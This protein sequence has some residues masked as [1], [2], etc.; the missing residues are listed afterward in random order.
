MGYLSILHDY[1]IFD[2]ILCVVLLITAYC[3]EY[4]TNLPSKVPNL[5][6]FIN[7]NEKSEI[8]SY[9]SI[10]I[11]TYGVGTFF[12]F[13]LGIITKID[14]TIFKK[15]SA[16]LFSISLTCFIV[17]IAKRLVERPRPDTL[18]VCGANNV[19][20]CNQMINGYKLYYQFTS[21][22]SRNAAEIASSSTFISMCLY[23][24]WTSDMMYSAFFK[25][26]PICWA[27]FIGGVEIVT[28]R[29]NPDDVI[30]GEMIGAAIAYFSY[31]S[32][33]QQEKISNMK[34]PEDAM[35]RPILSMYT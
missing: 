34:K 7:Q 22:P 11:F 15:M 6:S 29:A 3:I 17:S 14:K 32:M 30:A 16:Y 9:S 35:K 12:I 20:V 13:I 1:S 27:F 10:C 25:L 19:D 24:I 2:F 21:F 23:D 33:K 18:K 31:K 28:R 26:I 5:T 8:F 4:Y